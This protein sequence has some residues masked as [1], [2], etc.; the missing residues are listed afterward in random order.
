MR[1]GKEVG[2]QNV[3]D[4]NVDIDGDVE[5]IEVDYTDSVEGNIKGSLSCQRW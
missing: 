4:N 5:E 2:S 1:I 3:K